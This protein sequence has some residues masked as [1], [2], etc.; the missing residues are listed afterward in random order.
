M[1][2]GSITKAGKVKGQ[3]PRH[4]VLKTKQ[5]YNINPRGRALKRLKCTQR[6]G[7]HVTKLSP[8]SNLQ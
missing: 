5:T 3:T 8:N 7:D 4:D 1:P 2:H 6:F